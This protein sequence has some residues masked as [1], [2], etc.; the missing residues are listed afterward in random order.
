MKN[1]VYDRLA[2]AS[3]WRGIFLV[4]SAFGIYEFTPEQE[5]ALIVLSVAIFGGLHFV[6]DK[7]GK[8]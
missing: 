8:E 7:L 1:F 6:P 4:L 3:T 5:N 2:E